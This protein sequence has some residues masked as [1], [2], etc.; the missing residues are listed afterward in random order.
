[1]KVDGNDSPV[2]LPITATS[3]RDGRGRPKRSLLDSPKACSSAIA[4]ATT[5][6][7]RSPPSR[8][9]PSS[10]MAM[11]MY[12]AGGLAV[13]TIGGTQAVPGDASWNAF[14]TAMSP[15]R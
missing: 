1:M 15:G 14:A 9:A 3:S 4:A 6:N 13:A 8:H 7:A 10:A 5:S 2:G 12:F 11:R